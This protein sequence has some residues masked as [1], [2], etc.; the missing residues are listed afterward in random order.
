MAKAALLFGGIG[1]VLFVLA[2]LFCSPVFHAANYASTL[3]EIETTTFEE[4]RPPVVLH[5]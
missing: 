2:L 3:G 4:A 1:T 5:L